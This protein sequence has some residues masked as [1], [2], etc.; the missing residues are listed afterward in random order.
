LASELAWVSEPVWQS[1][2]VSESESPSAL[3]LEL[4]MVLLRASSSG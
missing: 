4:V 3:V 1:A 2:L